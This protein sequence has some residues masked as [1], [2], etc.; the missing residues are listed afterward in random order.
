MRAKQ[1]V[2]AVRADGVDQDGV[3]RL[4]VLRLGY[5][6]DASPPGAI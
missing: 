2:G 6:A 5:G 4:E 1:E 3:L